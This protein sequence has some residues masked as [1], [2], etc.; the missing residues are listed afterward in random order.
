MFIQDVAKL[1]V[2]DHYFGGVSKPLNNPDL[3]TSGVK[4]NRLMPL[5]GQN[6]RV[7][8]LPWRQVVASLDRQRC[9]TGQFPKAVM[10]QV[11]Q[12]RKKDGNPVAK[13]REVQIDSWDNWDKLIDCS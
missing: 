12:R 4:I 8:N 6:A 1:L 13:S 3:A 7:H 5:I 2:D 10:L 9:M 11:W